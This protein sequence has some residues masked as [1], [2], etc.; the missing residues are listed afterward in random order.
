MRMRVWGRCWFSFC[1]GSRVMI[2]HAF[3]LPS[4][5]TRLCIQQTI[6]PINQS[7]NQSIN[8]FNTPLISQKKRNQKK[9]KITSKPPQPQPTQ[10]QTRTTPPQK[11]LPQ[12]KHPSKRLSSTHCHSVSAPSNPPPQSPHHPIRGKT[13]PR[14]SH[15]TGKPIAGGKTQKPRPC[16]RSRRGSLCWIAGRGFR[17]RG[18]GGRRL[19]SGGMLGPVFILL[20][21]G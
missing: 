3:P 7:I 19:G 12:A 2:I 9:K 20:F 10:A 5:Y 17:R 18:R 8:Q 4:W 6:L 11:R 21:L 16:P 13:H 1:H 14:P 15:Q